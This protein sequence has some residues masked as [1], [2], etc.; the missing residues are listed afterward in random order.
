MS[1]IHTVSLTVKEQA[2][3]PTAAIQEYS[4]VSAL[5][6]AGVKN[7]G[8]QASQP[9]GRPSVENNTVYLWKSGCLVDDAWNCDLACMRP[10]HVWNDANAAFTYQNCVILPILA[11]SAANQWLV[12]DPPG[13]LAR[14]GISTDLT[15]SIENDPQR[16]LHWP[17]INSC[18]DRFCHEIRPNNEY[19]LGGLGHQRL[20][21]AVGPFDPPWYPDVVSTWALKSMT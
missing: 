12:E 7:M 14:Y 13:L 1:T 5:S 11:V 8:E 9:L 21:Y 16:S 4:L 17:V 6:D 15:T 10:T 18:T 20:K 2:A 3:L 19:C